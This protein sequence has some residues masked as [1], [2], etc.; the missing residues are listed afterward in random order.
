MKIK[1]SNFDKQEISE[2]LAD[3]SLIYVSGFLG[4]FIKVIGNS[5]GIEFAKE[6]SYDLVHNFADELYEEE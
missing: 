3:I 5:W 6:E 1:N 2:G 4:E